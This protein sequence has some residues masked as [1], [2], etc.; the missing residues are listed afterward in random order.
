[1]RILLTKKFLVSFSENRKAISELVKIVPGEGIYYIHLSL[2]R[3]MIN[4]N[5]RNSS[6]SVC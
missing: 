1:M 4:C 5:N 2:K 6:S 3:G